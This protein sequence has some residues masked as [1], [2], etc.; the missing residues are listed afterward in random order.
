MSEAHSSS[1]APT[2]KPDKPAPDFPLF[3]HATKRWAKKIRGKLVYFGPWDDP[4]GALQ[5]YQD[6]LAGNVA[7]SETRVPSPV[8]PGTPARPE[9][10]PLFWHATGRWAKKIR[11]SLRYFGRGSY[12]EA[13]AEYNRLAHDLH[14]GRRPA[15]TCPDTLTVYDLCAKFLTAKKDQRDGGELSPR[16]FVEYGDVCKRLIKAFGRNRVVSD[17]GPTDFAKLRKS[18]ARTWGPVRLKAEI[19][20]CRTPFLWASKSGLLD[21]PPVFGEV[22][23]VPA[24]AVIRRHRADRGPKMFEADEIR[25]MLD[26][27]GQPLK[28][29]ILLAINCGFGNSDVGT[30]PL[31]A[32][33]LDGGWVDYFRRKTG[34]DRRCPLWP[35]TVAAIREWMAERKAPDAQKNAGVVFTTKYGQPWTSEGRALPHET[36]K[37]LKRLGINGHRN[38]YAFRHTFQTVGDEAGD[39]IATRRIMGHTSKDIADVYRERVSDQRLKKVTEHIR[40]WLFGPPATHTDKPT[41]SPTDTSA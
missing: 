17:V 38:F 31:S 22:F 13:F 16:M 14:A 26:A 27:A 30:L 33:D 2:N 39:F 12:D 21:R 10:S 11:G 7:Q 1:S 34:I 20:R 24:A 23:K 36:R 18:M 40:A 8:E 3:A 32:L 6:Y 4:K 15:D 19:I 28:S 41:S 29:M 5:R 9:G 35:E 25:T 37:L